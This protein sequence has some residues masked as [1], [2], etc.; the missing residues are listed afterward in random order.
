MPE[1]KKNNNFKKDQK[2]KRI[3]L[4]QIFK[5]ILWKAC[6]T[7]KVSKEVFGVIGT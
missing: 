1:P 3:S 7:E 2:S 6:G 4:T 5:L